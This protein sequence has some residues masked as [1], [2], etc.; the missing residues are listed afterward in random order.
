MTE[1][2]EKWLAMYNL[3]HAAGIL[4]AESGNTEARNPLWLSRVWLESQ[5]RTDAIHTESGRTLPR[6]RKIFFAKTYCNQ[7]GESE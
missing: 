6:V 4:D 5:A 2:D 1:D 3:L 7:K